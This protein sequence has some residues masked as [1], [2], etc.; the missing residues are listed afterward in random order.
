MPLTYGA[1]GPRDASLP[2]AVE[3]V[4]GF[5]HDPSKWPYMQYVQFKPVPQEGNGLYR[6][7]IIEPD[8]PARLVNYYDHAWAWDAQMPG[9]EM[10]KPRI[11]WDGGETKRWAFGYT[12]GERT[13]KSWTNATSVNPQNLYDRMRMNQAMLHRASRAVDTVR[14][15]TFSSYNTSSLQSLG[16]LN[17]GGS[18][19]DQSSGTELTASGNPNPAFQIIKRTCNI[20]QRRI[21]LQTNG[22]VKG[23]E[24]IVVLGPKAAQRVAESGEIVNYIKQQTGAKQDLMQRNEKWN[25]PDK[26]YGWNWVVEDTPRVFLP[27]LIDGQTF[28]N[29]ATATTTTGS[30]STVAYNQ[31][32]Y[33]WNDDSVIFCSRAGGLDGNYGDTNFSTFQMFHYNG[34]ADVR[35]ETDSWNQLLKGVIILEDD[36]K[37]VAPLSGFLLTSTMSSLPA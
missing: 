25:I 14:G 11:S 34:L 26:L 16:G 32:D 9:G 33:I 8:E 29:P 17:A 2:A 10:F 20:I 13:Q 30:G 6:Y 36:F 3:Q 12:I 5:M 27:Q 31:R 22:A 18:Y 15:A 19:W 7:P 23:E 21:D 24:M 37:V 35:A 4:I 28:A 1:M